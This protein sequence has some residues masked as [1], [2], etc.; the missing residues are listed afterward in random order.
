M[1]VRPKEVVVKRWE[2][3]KQVSTKMLCCHTTLYRIF[4]GFNGCQHI[5]KFSMFPCTPPYHLSSPRKFHSLFMPL[6]RDVK[7]NWLVLALPWTIRQHQKRKPPHSITV[8]WVG[9]CVCVCVC[10]CIHITA[11]QCVFHALTPSLAEPL[12][13]NNHYH[14]GNEVII[15]DTHIPTYT[16]THIP[17]LSFVFLPSP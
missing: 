3:S 17:I 7:T 4:R 14:Q 6:H 16:L 5:W 1:N 2:I 13:I 12:V 8:Q 11:P 10:T 15:T 9:V